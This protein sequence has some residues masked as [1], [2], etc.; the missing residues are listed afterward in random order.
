[1]VHLAFLST[2]MILSEHII[3]GNAVGGNKFFAYHERWVKRTKDDIAKRL[4][5]LS[6]NN[7][8]IIGRKSSNVYT[9]LIQTVEKA[10]T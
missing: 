7:Y 3:K 10:I 4:Q 5:I 1:M 2:C 6:L 8:V 9:E